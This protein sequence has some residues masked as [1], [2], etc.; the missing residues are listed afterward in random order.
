MAEYDAFKFRARILHGLALFSFII[1]IYTK[2][3][4]FRLGHSE[5]YGW[6]VEIETRTAQIIL[7]V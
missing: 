3:P 2:L 7:T 6:F 1:F 4:V 5:E